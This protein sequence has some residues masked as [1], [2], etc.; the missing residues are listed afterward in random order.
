MIAR[1]VRKHGVL[2]AEHINDFK[3]SHSSYPAL[4][5]TQLPLLTP[6]VWQNV[7]MRAVPM[8]LPYCQVSL[9]NMA[10]LPATSS[11]SLLLALW[12]LCRSRR[13]IQDY[14]VM[15]LRKAMFRW[16]PWRGKHVVT[17]AQT[18]SNAGSAE[19][20]CQSSAPLLPLVAE[21]C[22]RDCWQRGGSSS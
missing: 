9:E 17:S 7:T 4:S 13:D 11:L 12:P 1:L 3:V 15:L 20:H 19:M 2:V 5:L 6:E 14:L 21:S 16:G 10:F 8:P 18:S 22:I